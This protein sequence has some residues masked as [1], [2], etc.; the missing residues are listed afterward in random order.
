MDVLNLAFEG[1]DQ[2][3]PFLKSGLR[4]VLNST[5]LHLDVID[6]MLA[7]LSADFPAAKGPKIFGELFRDARIF[8][9]IMRDEYQSRADNRDDQGML[10]YCFLIMTIGAYLYLGHVQ[11]HAPIEENDVGDTIAAMNV[12]RGSWQADHRPVNP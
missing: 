1:A 9:W 10:R 4:A 7:K 8:L 5:S 11:D 3:L 12:V 6:A 2:P